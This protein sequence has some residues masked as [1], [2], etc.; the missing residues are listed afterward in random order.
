MCHLQLSKGGCVLSAQVGLRLG[1]APMVDE[2]HDWEVR[3][4]SLGESSD[5]GQAV[6]EKVAAGTV[7]K[8]RH[9]HGLQR[10]H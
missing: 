4:V 7:V 10:Q 6:G 8:V 1:S 9:G 5:L 2:H 3:R